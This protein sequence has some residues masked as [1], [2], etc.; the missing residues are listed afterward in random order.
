MRL[1]VGGREGLQ[2]GRRSRSGV[3]EGTS[4]RVTADPVVGRGVVGEVASDRTRDGTREDQTAVG[5]AK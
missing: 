2:K 1:R 5:P 4:R 3:R